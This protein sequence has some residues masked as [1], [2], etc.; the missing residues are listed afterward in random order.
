LSEAQRKK[1]FIDIFGNTNNYPLLMAQGT[2]L[3]GHNV[4][5]VLN[6]KDLLH[7]PEARYPDWVNACPD[8]IGDYSVELS[9]NQECWS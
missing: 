4:R 5:L 7:R 8:W 9:P 1:L 3:P 6:R 2:R